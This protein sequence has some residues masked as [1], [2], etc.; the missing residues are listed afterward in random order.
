LVTGSLLPA[1]TSHRF[2]AESN[3]DAPT[4]LSF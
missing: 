1:M 2:I 3:E 4:S